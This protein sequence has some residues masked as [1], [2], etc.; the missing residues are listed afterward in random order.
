MTS[1]TH[2]V[3]EN[4]R[5]SEHWKQDYHKTIDMLYAAEINSDSAI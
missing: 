1:I 5:C 3:E 2:A 4:I